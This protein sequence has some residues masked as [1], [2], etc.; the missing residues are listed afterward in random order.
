MFVGNLRGMR[1]SKLRPDSYLKIAPAWNHLILL[2]KTPLQ[3]AV[4]QV[5]ESLARLLINN[6]ANMQTFNNKKLSPLGVAISNRFV[7]LT[8]LLRHELKNKNL[9]QIAASEFV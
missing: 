5:H 8:R 4:D 9:E 3:E 2:T 6:G 1:C 7:G